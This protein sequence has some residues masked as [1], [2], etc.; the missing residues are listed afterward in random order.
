MNEEQIAYWDG[1][2]GQRWTEQQMVLDRAL[3]AFGDAVVER[4]A[5]RPGE[6]VLDVGCGCGASSITLSDRV[7]A[8]GSV[9]G[10]DLSAQMLERAR[11]RAGTRANLSFARGDVTTFSFPRTYDLV[12]SRFG[13]MFFEDPVAA[14]RQ[15]RTAVRPNG[16]LVFVSWRA[17][18]DNP[19]AALP[20]SAIRS[21]LPGAP[22]SHF[23]SDAPGPY[24]FAD[25]KKVEQIL[26]SSGFRD[27]QIDPFDGEVVLAGDD[28]DQAVEFAVNA[29]PALRILASVS[30]DVHARAKD[31][32]RR[33]IEPMRTRNGFALA[34]SSW[35]V[36]AR[37]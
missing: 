21:V 6:H 30:P 13:V 16:R 2:A 4:A 36:S 31:A 35:L 22:L 18:E 33:A 32:V 9:L 24:A 34:G 15:L 11:E 10:V 29:G 3:A 5:A 26:L 12:F 7:G 17:F 27:I 37:T 20:V 19:W 8:T 25:V 14:F 28:L 23:D 1:P